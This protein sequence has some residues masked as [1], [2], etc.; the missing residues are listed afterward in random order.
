MV[1]AK[2]AHSPIITVKGTTGSNHCLSNSS[3]SRSRGENRRT[4]AAKESTAIDIAKAL[5]DPV[6]TFPDSD[7]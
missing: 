4:D 7:P 1:S 2:Y 5:P 6:S 3:D